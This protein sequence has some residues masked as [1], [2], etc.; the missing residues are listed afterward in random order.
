M[1]QDVEGR[2]TCVFERVLTSDGRRHQIHLEAIPTSAFSIINILSS[3][4]SR[5]GRQRGR[6]RGDFADG[7]SRQRRR[8]LT[9][10]MVMRLVPILGA[11]GHTASHLRFTT[12]AELYNLCIMRIRPCLVTIPGAILP[13]PYGGQDMQVMDQSRSAE[14]ARPSPHPE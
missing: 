13:H 4:R 3:G 10:P 11:G 9:P 12:P 2:I 7:S 14:I 8:I 5:P 6:Y 1:P